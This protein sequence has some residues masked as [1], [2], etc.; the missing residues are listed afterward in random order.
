MTDLS[1]HP[2]GRLLASASNDR[3]VRIWALAHAQIPCVGV[4]EPPV[5]PIVVGAVAP[6]VTP[7]SPIVACSWRPQA[8]LDATPE[9]LAVSQVTAS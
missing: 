6:A 9:L 4:L 7:S 5:P 3:T 1:V 2:S 8:R